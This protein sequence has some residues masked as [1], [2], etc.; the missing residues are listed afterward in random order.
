MVKIFTDRQVKTYQSLKQRAILKI[1]VPFFRRTYALT[2]GLKMKPLRKAFSSVKTKAYPNF[3]VKLAERSNHFT[4]YLMNHIFQIS[5]L[6]MEGIDC[7]NI[8]KRSKA[9][10]QPFLY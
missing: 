4:A 1:P 5:V 10:N 8:S 6:I 2:V 3:A 9:A 7:V